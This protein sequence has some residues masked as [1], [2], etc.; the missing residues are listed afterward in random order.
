MTN[1][2]TKEDAIDEIR[3]KVD[4]ILAI[5]EGNGEPGLKTKVAIH[6]VYFRLIAGVGGP[7]L[8]F[9]TARTVWSLI[10]G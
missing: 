9:L 3:H 1:P 5:L 10:S 2:C 8:V 4:R 6:R 7:I